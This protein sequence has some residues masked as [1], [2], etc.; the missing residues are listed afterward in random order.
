MIFQE[1]MTSLNPVFRV[2]SQITAAIRLKRHIAKAR[3]PRPGRGNCSPRSA[4]RTRNNVSTTTRTSFRAAC[5][6]ASWSPWRSRAIPGLLIADEPTTALDV[7]IQAQILELLRQL[8]KDLGMAVLLITHDLGI[9]AETAHRVAIMYAGKIVEQAATLTLF[10]EPKHPYTVGLFASLPEGLGD[11]RSDWP[12]SPR[13]CAGGVTLPDRMPVP[14]AMPACHGYLPN[15]PAARASGRRRSHNR[16]LAVRGQGPMT[17]GPHRGRRVFGTDRGLAAFCLAVLGT[18]RAVSFDSAPLAGLLRRKTRRA[19]W[20]SRLGRATEHRGGVRPFRT[21]GRTSRVRAGRVVRPIPVSRP[22]D[23]LRAGLSAV[24]APTL[25][26]V[27]GFYYLIGRDGLLPRLVEEAFGV[28]GFSIQGAGAILL[29]HTYSFSTFFYA[30]MTSALSNLDRAQIEAAR[31][32]G[33]SVGVYSGR[34]SCRC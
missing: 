5:A 29:I 6:S 30:T 27:L 1:P 21:D 24:H 17:P 18:D 4:S 14:P 20:G 8:Q 13:K 28:H 25:V 32:L 3:R 34:S 11:A 12:R 15:H 7:T 2:G 10:N 33:A 22:P 31:T 19:L 26:G 9:V 23:A 16:V